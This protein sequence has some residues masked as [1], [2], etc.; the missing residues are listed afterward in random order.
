MWYPIITNILYF[1]PYFFS[2]F[3]KLE[4]N[5]YDLHKYDVAL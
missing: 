1:V 2:F 4:Q 5:M 3:F